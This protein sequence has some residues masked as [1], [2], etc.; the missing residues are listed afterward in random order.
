MTKDDI[1]KEILRNHTEEDVLID[2]GEAK[3]N[4]IDTDDMREY[5]DIDEAYI[6]LGRGEA[7]SE[8]LMGILSGYIIDTDTY[9]DIWDT[10][11]EEWD[12]S[13]E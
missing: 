7:E 3:Y 11:C 4:F 2:I 5:D 6:D 1:I 13:T 8:V 12:I 9:L 10:L